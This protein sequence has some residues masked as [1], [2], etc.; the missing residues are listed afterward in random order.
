TRS[1]THFPSTTLFRSNTEGS[2]NVAL[3][4]AKHWRRVEGLAR[5]GMGMADL[6]SRTVGVRALTGLTA[7][8]RMAISKDLVPSV[9]GPMPQK[10]S[11][12][13]TS[14][15]QSRENL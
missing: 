11:E 15:L 5:L 6:I 9:P 2:E 8:A 1:S 7:V 10:R 14:E 13:H 4:I 3:I 12:E